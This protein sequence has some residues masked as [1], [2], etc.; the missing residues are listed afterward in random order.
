MHPEDDNYGMLCHT[1]W[2]LHPLLTWFELLRFLL[3][4]ATWS[5]HLKWPWKCLRF[6]FYGFRPK[7]FQKSSSLPNMFK[8]VQKRTVYANTLNVCF[9]WTAG[10]VE[11]SATC[12]RFSPDVFS[13]WW[14]QTKL[15]LSNKSGKCRARHSRATLSLAFSNG[16]SLLVA[17]CIGL[18]VLLSFSLCFLTWLTSESV[19]NWSHMLASLHFQP[20]LTL[21]PS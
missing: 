18:A 4:H 16:F 7:T 5:V 20:R 3:L 2:G 15:L 10:S 13:P 6:S 14:A 11:T 1:T 19:C 12:M 17:L 21:F 9:W 8:R